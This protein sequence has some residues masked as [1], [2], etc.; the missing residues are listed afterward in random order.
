MGDEMEGRL[1]A[2]AAFVRKSLGVAPRIG[3]VLGSGLGDFATLVEVDS[4]I[5]YADIPG[6]PAATVEGHAG[7]FVFGHLDGVAVM[8]MQGR[9]HYYEGYDMAD[10]VMPIRLMRLLGVEA[11][12]LTNA[13][14][15]ITPALTP[16]TFMLVTDHLSFLVPSPL[17]G[18]NLDGLG[19]RFPDMSH[20]YDPGLLDLARTAAAAEAI[21]LREGVYI[22]TAG[23]NFET[24][25]EIRMYGRLGADAVGMSTACEA[26]AARH[27]GLRV[28]AL[29]CIA[30][31]AAGISP[32]PL[33][34]EE[35]YEVSVRRA[36]EFQR[37]LRRLIREAGAALPPAGRGRPDGRPRA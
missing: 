2:A 16:G 15:G 12:V 25:A 19:P 27:C 28:C 24:P 9:V 35:V 23:P 6:F 8:V 17:R 10:V 32:T 3:V 30:N 31:L 11:A 1:A 33:S 7:R 18:A 14:G 36:P 22:Q 26:T 21:D 5:S 37:L 34:I 29:S 20:V 4:V 13:A